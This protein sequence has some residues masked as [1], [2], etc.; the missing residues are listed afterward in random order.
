MTGSPFLPKTSIKIIQN[1]MMQ[2]MY[3]ALPEVNSSFLFDMCNCIALTIQLSKNETITRQSQ[4]H[5]V[6]AFSYTRVY[7]HSMLV[8]FCH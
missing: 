3:G 5:Y 7:G 2:L 6:S 4:F 8:C 1:I